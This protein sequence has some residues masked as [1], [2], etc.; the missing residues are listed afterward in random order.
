MQLVDKILQVLQGEVHKS[1][2]RVVRFAKYPLGQTPKQLPV[3][4]TK[5]VII[6]KP[7]FDPVVRHVV[8][9]LPLL[10]QDTQRVLQ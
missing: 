1:Q 4:A 5:S 10:K 2:K 9:L 8:Q 6:I 3:L 7:A